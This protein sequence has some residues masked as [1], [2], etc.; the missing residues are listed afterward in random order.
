M[1]KKFSMERIGSIDG[2]LIARVYNG[3]VNI[4]IINVHLDN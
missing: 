4:F 1:S 3:Y 2:A